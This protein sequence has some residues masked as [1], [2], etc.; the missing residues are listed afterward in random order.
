[1]AFFTEWLSEIFKPQ[2]GVGS[3]ILYK[4]KGYLV[5]RVSEEGGLF[6]DTYLWHNTSSMNQYCFYLPPTEVKNVIV[7]KY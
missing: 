6:L 4:N 5:N 1:M 3:H 7:L 2:I